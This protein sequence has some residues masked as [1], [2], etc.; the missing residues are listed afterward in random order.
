MDIDADSFSIIAVR[1]YEKDITLNVFL[2]KK[3]VI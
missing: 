2:S 1:W 3:G